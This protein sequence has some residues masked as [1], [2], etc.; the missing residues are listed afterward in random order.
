MWT[1]SSRAMPI[2]PVTFSCDIIIQLCKCI[3]WMYNT[4]WYDLLVHSAIKFSTWFESTLCVQFRK[5]CMKCTII[6]VK[7]GKLLFVYFYFNCI[8]FGGHKSGKSVSLVRWLYLF[9]RRLKICFNAP[10]FGNFSE[11]SC[12]SLSYCISQ[13]H[14]PDKSRP[15]QNQSRTI[16]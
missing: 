2:L 3:N 9:F 7:R 14:L 6:D 4:Q 11:F 10:D 13:P 8:L 15:E 12:V 1:N 16:S 5:S